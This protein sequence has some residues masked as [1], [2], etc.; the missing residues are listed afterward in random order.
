M[1]CKFRGQFPPTGFTLIEI[2]VTIVVIGIAAVAVMGVFT[3]TVSNSAAPLIQQQAISIAEAYIEEIQLK[4]FC[5]DA[6][7][8]MT[9]PTQP[10]PGCPSETGGAEA[11]ETRDT[12]N[13]VQDYSDASV[14]GVVRDQNG[15]AIAGLGDYSVTVDV[16]T[17]A[18]DSI[19]DA[20]RIDVS[21]NHPA[22][23][24]IMLSTF[25]TNY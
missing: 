17:A 18:L 24:P 25:R 23:E 3:S 1:H 22:I 13:D 16:T 4:Q 10:P 19:A 8:P 9:A 14:D 7:P 20:L 21:V 11:G 2:L 12:Y 6:P 15:T 5:H